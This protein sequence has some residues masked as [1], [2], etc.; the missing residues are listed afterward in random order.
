M[1]RVLVTVA[2]LVVVIAGGAVAWTLTRPDAPPPLAVDQVGGGEAGEEP[3]ASL[4]ELDGRWEVQAGEDT[5]AGLRIDEERAAG[6]GDHTAVGRTGEVTGELVLDAGVVT[7]GSFVVDLAS[8]EFTDDPG[9]PVAN[10]SEYLRTQAL[11]TDAFPEARFELTEPV[12]LPG[13]DGGTRRGIEVPGMLELHGVE[14][15]ATITVDVRVDGRQVVLGTSEP[16]VVRLADH[17]IVAPEIPGV[18]E[19]ADE[20]S[21][22]FLVVLTRA[23]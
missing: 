14:Q 12:A 13:L 4:D 7:E 20:G 18:A 22:E 9:L 5:V 2:V 3:Q 16:V 21:F 23:A 19:V 1:K 6:L 10:R 11:E 15:P 17:D 8:I